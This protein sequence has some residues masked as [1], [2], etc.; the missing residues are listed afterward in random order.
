MLNNI[1]HHPASEIYKT[2][3]VLRFLKSHRF[4]A[5]SLALYR[6]C[7]LKFY[8]TYVRKFPEPERELDSADMREISNAYH[9]SLK[10]LYDAGISATSEEY[11]PKMRE[12][13]NKEI[14]LLD[15]FTKNA[16]GMF[17]LAALL[18]RFK[19]LAKHERARIEA[20]AKIHWAEKPVSCTI[21]GVHFRGYIDR[22][23]LVPGGYALIDYKY[24]TIDKVNTKTHFDRLDL[25][26]PL[27][28][29]MIEATEG[30]TPIELL[31]CDIKGDKGFMPAFDPGRMKEF[32]V[33]LGELLANI[34]YEG[35]PFDGAKDRKECGRC[36][37]TTICKYA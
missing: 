27:Y 36:H 34:F 8:Y 9:K 24:K 35:A 13:F 29:L 4:S 1:P 31:W 12:F 5:T 15:Y 16:V 22:I 26:L 14:S 6:S 3:E 19:T 7:P 20:G 37:Y 18:D 25:Q 17:E 30:F 23:D 21:Q 33:Y 32:R 28:A 10:N 11:L 2:P